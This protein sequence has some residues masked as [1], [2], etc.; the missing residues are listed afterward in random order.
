MLCLLIF[1]A[2]M[3]AETSELCGRLATWAIPLLHPASTKAAWQIQPRLKGS[4]SWSLQT[5][6]ELLEHS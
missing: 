1:L 3:L 5:T 4:V 2:W 6:I